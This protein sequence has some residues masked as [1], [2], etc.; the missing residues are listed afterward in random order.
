MNKKLLIFCKKCKKETDHEDQGRDIRPDR[1]YF[2]KICKRCNEKW[3]K[4][5]QV[6]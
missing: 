3:K 4:L 5:N 6:L 2:C 1:R